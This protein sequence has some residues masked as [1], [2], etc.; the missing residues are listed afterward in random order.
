MKKLLFAFCVV[1]L[2]F[3]AGCRDSGMDHG[4]A[5]DGDDTHSQ[6]AGTD[7][8]HAEELQTAQITVWTNGYEVFAEHQAPVAGKATTFITHVTDLHTLEPRLEGIVKFILRHGDA[9]VE[10]PQA[11]PARAGI[12]LP[13]II[14]PN[15]GDW[16][17]SLIIPADGT[18]ALVEL[19]TVKVHADQ[20]AAAHAEFPE[21]P[22]GL[23]FLKEQQW[24]IRTRTEPVTRRRLVE[25]AIL[26]ATA[27]AKPG[28]N[29]SVVAPMAGQL[30]TAPGAEFPSPGQKV[31][32]GE[33]LAMLRPSFSE[34]AVKFADSEGEFVRAQAAFEKAE[35]SYDRT[36]KL[37]Q[38]QAKSERELQEAELELL[39][40]RARFEA[41]AALRSTYRQLS[42]VHMG[43]QSSPSETLAGLEL[44]APISG[45]VNDVGAGLGEPISADQ[46]VFRILNPEV[47]WIEAR[48]PEAS[49]QRIPED[50]GASFAV[51]NGS[52][53]VSIQAAGGR[54]VFTGM[55]V[56]PVT[57]TVPLVYEA[58]NL[59]PRLR[60]GQALSLHVE[61]GHARDALA[62]PD[63]AIVEEEG[64]YVAFV[65][66]SGETFDKRELRLGIRDGNFVQ[67]LEGLS[68]GERV[69][70][71]G[72]MAIRLAS[73]SGVIPAHDHA[74]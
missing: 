44:R 3:A 65:Q 1:A 17:L 48:V 30:L 19:G 66:V 56:D 24:K 67:V 28:F 45:I 8:D 5:H 13:D 16:H 18:N 35:L 62:V 40:A 47:V 34:A 51:A 6:E 32:A 11:A 4:H 70:T 43:D 42:G 61:T 68:E 10:H 26:P 12:Y 71:Q 41:S 53:F 39:T 63:S 20:H 52:G 73:V 60:I 57:R 23:S 9:I 74:H 33:L 27:M 36:K 21:T 49:L 69:V 7:H 22:E 64:R 29:A 50:A 15:T 46:V 72:A 58:P 59:V 38:Q 25:H 55:A 2:G 37:A 54:R 31:E 14:F